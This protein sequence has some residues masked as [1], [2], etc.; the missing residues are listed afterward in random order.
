MGR[1]RTARMRAEALRDNPEVQDDV[2][3]RL[4]EIT[5]AQGPWAEL[6][7]TRTD[8]NDGVRAQSQH[9]DAAVPL[10]DGSLRMGGTLYLLEQTGQSERRPQDWS[11]GFNQP[12]GSRVSLAAQVGRVDDVGGAPAST[13][14]L[15]LGVRAAPGLNIA[16]SQDRKS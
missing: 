3:S 11:L 9:L 12:L 10:L 2:P 8:S 1:L 6:S 16:L 14:R 7:Q 13:H 5:D 15:S 4:R